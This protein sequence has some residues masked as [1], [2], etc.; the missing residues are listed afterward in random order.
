MR[1]WAKPSW[2][3]RLLS[4][5]VALILMGC[6][7]SSEAFESAPMSGQQTV[8][9][10]GGAPVSRD[11]QRARAAA[12]AEARANEAAKRGQVGDKSKM[13]P[14]VQQ[15]ARGGNQGVDIADPRAWD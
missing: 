14:S 3:N 15:P 12:A 2:R 11:E 10:V 13:K 1:S 8:G 9:K 7:G 6:C 5:L 4:E